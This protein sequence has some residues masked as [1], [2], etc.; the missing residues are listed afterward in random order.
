L[1]LCPLR[2]AIEKACSFQSSGASEIPTAKVR[3]RSCGMASASFCAKSAGICS[4]KRASPSW[5][6]V[7]QRPVAKAASKASVLGD[8]K[9]KAGPDGALPQD[10][11]LGRE[12]THYG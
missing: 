4:V 8:G 3:S 5:S 7:K 1:P 10:T 9:K 12:M 11:G 2:K 6:S